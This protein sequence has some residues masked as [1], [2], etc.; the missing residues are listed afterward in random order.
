MR[1]IRRQQAEWVR[2]EAQQS[3][4]GEQGREAVAGVAPSAVDRNGSVSGSLDL[5][6]ESYAASADSRVLPCQMLHSEGR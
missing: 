5:Y 3:G 4:T 2:A 6:T 1:E